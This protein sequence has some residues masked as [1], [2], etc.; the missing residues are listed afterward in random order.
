MRVRLVTALHVHHTH[1]LHPKK[2]RISVLF[3][4]LFYLRI[5]IDV[6]NFNRDSHPSLSTI[7]HGMVWYVKALIRETARSAVHD[8][9]RAS[10]RIRSFALIRCCSY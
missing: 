3:F 1:L 6:D 7:R 8:R 5:G 10:E 4:S 9:A 2:F